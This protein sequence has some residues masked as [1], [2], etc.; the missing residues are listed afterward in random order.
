MQPCAGERARPDIKSR[1]GPL[2]L[3]LQVIPSLSRKRGP[4]LR[5]L[6]PSVLALST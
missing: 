6:R 2:Q 4:R 5:R 3:S 1:R